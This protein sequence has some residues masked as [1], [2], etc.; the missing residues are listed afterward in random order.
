MHFILG[1]GGTGKS[2]WIS[3]TSQ[4]AEKTMIQTGDNP[5]RPKI[6]LLA[7]TGKAASLIGKCCVCSCTYTHENQS[8]I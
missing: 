5:N 8:F 6:L 1:D 4:W 2:Y 7:P 3:I